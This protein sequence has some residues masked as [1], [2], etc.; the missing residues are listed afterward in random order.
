MY[1]VNR[2]S[3]AFMIEISLD[4]YDEIFNG[5]DASQIKRK[6]LEPEL[7]EY[8]LSASYE[9][10]L[11]E[12]IEVCFY[13]KEAFLNQEKEETSRI[14]IGYNF[15]MRL[16]FLNMD[17]HRNSRRIWTYIAMSFLFLLAAYLIPNYIDLNVLFSILMEGLFIGGWVLLWEAFSLFFFSTH[18]IRVRKKH[19]LRLLASP[20]EFKYIKS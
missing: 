18:D 9:I 10:P 17:I 5:W 3:K 13:M 4:D 6:E 11:K 1:S 8:L 20:I 12:D 14:G 16:H 15:K 2:L 19:I 7:F